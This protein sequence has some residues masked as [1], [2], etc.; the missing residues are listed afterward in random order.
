MIKTK[1]QINLFD[2][3]FVDCFAG[4]GGWS[5]GA[6]L[7]L[8]RPMDIAVNH[9]PDAVLMHKTNHP[10]TRHYCEDIY[11]VPP[12]DA[13]NGRH[14]AWAHFSPDCTHHS[15]AKGGKPVKKRYAGSHGL[16]CAGRQKSARTLSVWRTSK[17]FYH[18]DRYGMAAR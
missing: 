7:A 8:G 6:E 13:V 14:V 2:P 18:G 16:F 5:T 11:S 4:G 10:F 1:S 15:R 17:N 12:R 3:I 9:D